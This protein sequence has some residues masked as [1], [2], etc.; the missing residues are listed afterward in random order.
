MQ[1]AFKSEKSVRRLN[2]LAVVRVRGTVDV[3]G[4]VQDTLKILG[5]TRPNHCVLVN[6]DSSTQGML[7]EAK[8]FITWGSLKP[9]VLESLIRKRGRLEGG[10]PVTDEVINSKTQFKTI[11]EFTKAIIEGEAEL[12]EVEGL[13]KVFRLRPPKKGYKSTKRPFQ[14]GGSLGFRSE[15]MNDLIKR[16]I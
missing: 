1:S 5:L 10:A 4:K 11:S 15:K 12:S 2:K 9:E 6:V 8:D 7:Q 16:M 3:R 14:D 13:K